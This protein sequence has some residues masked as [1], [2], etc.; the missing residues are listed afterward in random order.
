M[1]MT[2]QRSAKSRAPETPTHYTKLHQGHLSQKTYLQINN[3]F[4]SKT[5]ISIGIQIY[6]FAAN[7]GMV[8]DFYLNITSAKL[9][10]ILRHISELRKLNVSFRSFF[11]H[12]WFA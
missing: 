10:E 3:R 12:K 11:F 7:S 1:L 5:M 6:I 4:M 2:P 9:C 8:R